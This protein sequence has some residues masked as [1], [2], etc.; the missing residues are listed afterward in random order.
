MAKNKKAIGIRYASQT[1][2]LC[3]ILMILFGCVRRTPLENI[4]SR[5]EVRGIDISAHNGPIDFE[6]I[7]NEGIDFV[8][9]K[10]SEGSGFKDV[11]FFDNYRNARKAGLKVGAYH[12]F[13]FDVP[14]HM[15][16]LNYLN[17]IRGRHLDFPLVI[18]L[19]EWGNPRGVSTDLIVSRLEA[20]LAHVEL[21]GHPIMIYTNKR[22]YE[23]FIKNRFENY[24]LWICSFTPLTPDVNW[25]FWQYS[26]SGRLKGAKGNVDLNVFNGN[27]QQWLEWCDSIGGTI[28]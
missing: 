3:I 27:R 4:V 13:R 28:Q 6:R 14:G 8:F 18:D 9:M 11:A 5:Y 23:R 1:T 21:S 15:Q 10:A 20:F 19:E 7:R 12:F 2:S 26:H 17:S 16:S 24:P 25:I 22:G